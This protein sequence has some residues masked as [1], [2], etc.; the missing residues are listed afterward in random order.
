ML[1]PSKATRADHDQTTARITY[2]TRHWPDEE[3]YDGW[4]AVNLSPLMN[5]KGNEF[6]QE[7]SMLA[8]A[9]Q[10]S[11]LLDISEAGKAAAK[12]VVAYGTVK[13]SRSLLAKSLQAFGESRWCLG[14]NAKKQPYHPKR[15]EGVLDSAELARRVRLFPK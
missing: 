4:I 8:E 11:N 6:S 5:P 14:H 2:Y 1:N 10:E 7:V 15:R 13:V 3:V 9:D 12:C